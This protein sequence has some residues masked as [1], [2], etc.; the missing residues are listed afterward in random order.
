MALRPGCGPQGSGGKSR[1]LSA[2]FKLPWPRCVSGAPAWRS[3]LVPEALPPAQQPARW[4]SGPWFWSV[5]SPHPK[6]GS[7]CFSLG[8]GSS[9]LHWIR[10]KQGGSDSTKRIREGCL[11]TFDP[12]F[13]ICCPRRRS[14]LAS[15]GFCC[16]PLC[17]CHSPLIDA[18]AGTRGVSEAGPRVDSAARPACQLH[19]PPGLTCKR[20][21]PGWRFQLEQPRFLCS[22]PAS[23]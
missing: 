1:C 14:C 21:G 11:L 2:G 12:C 5:T 15:E 17:C 19:T 10:G 18:A 20:R 8:R 23:Y 4:A 13:I 6:E 9:C 16:Q 7:S 3:G 22:G